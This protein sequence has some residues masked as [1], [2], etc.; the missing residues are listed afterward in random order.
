M[1]KTSHSPYS[2]SIPVYRTHN[3]LIKLLEW[4]NYVV[5]F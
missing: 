4:R 3:F 5:D 2:S 1:E